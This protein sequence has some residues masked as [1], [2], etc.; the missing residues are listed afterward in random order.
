LVS[1]DQSLLRDKNSDF[2]SL[3]RKKNPKSTPI[4]RF[5]A[6][7]GFKS[8]VSSLQITANDGF[9]AYL[10]KIINYCN[11]TYQNTVL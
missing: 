6:V 11:E 10:K 2:H 7:F 8:S 3:F 1:F 4:S 9:I 5:K